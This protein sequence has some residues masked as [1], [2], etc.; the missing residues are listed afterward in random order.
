VTQRTLEER[1]NRAQ[2]QLGSGGYDVRGDLASL[3]PRPPAADLRHP[4]DVSDAELVDAAARTIARMLADVR[5]LT[6][7]RKRLARELERAQ[8]EPPP[9]VSVFAFSSR[10]RK[11]SP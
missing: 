2:A 6:R 3:L 4:D 1:G 8:A 11:A 5:S 10:R 9:R 7:E